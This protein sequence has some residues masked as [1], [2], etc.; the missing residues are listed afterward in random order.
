[1]KKI[2]YFIIMICFTLLL[3]GCVSNVIR[4]EIL[5]KLQKEDYIK[6]DWKEVDTV[7]NSN[8][9]VPSIASYEYIYQD[10]DEELNKIVIY[11]NRDGEEEYNVTICYDVEKNINNS[12]EVSYIK[13]DTRKDFIF[14]K[15]KIL[16]F[17]YWKMTEIIVD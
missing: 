3:T 10:K 9:P 14:E 15:K 16:M 2:L 4:T 7:V 8:T 1:M 6:S 5:E 13:C 17:E 12:G 11:N